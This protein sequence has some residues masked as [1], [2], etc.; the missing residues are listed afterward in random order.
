MIPDGF[1]VQG[2]IGHPPGPVLDEIGI[3]QTAVTAMEDLAFMNQEANLPTRNAR[4]WSLPQ[5]D[6]RIYVRSTRVRWAIYGLLISVPA[7]GDARIA[8]RPC[9]IFLFLRGHEEGLIK[10]AHRDDPF[11]RRAISRTGVSDVISPLKPSL[12][13]SGDDVSGVAADTFDS[14]LYVDDPEPST[15]ASNSS[16]HG[17]RPL[18][19]PQ[20]R[21][22][23]RYNGVPMT[24]QS[25]FIAALSAMVLG[26]EKGP[27]TLCPRV[28]ADE[29]ELTPIID[30]TGRST[31]RFRSLIKAMRLL[32]GWMVAMNRYGEIDVEL[33]RAGAVIGTVQLR[34]SDSEVA[35]L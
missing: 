6:V 5:Y 26:A 3:Y 15:L 27:D 34:K 13:S 32:T 25:V 10:F 23:P 21:I 16:R 1:T 12:N 14:L 30:V 19:V 22:V 18:S 4:S 28:T 9:L 11:S 29:W 31:M 8:F 2:I 35:G 17:N 20:L 7:I 24:S 33:Q